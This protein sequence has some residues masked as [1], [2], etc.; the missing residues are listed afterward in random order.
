MIPVNS[1]KQLALALLSTER[2]YLIFEKTSYF[3]PVVPR[4]LL[5]GLW[6]TV[7]NG[8]WPSESVTRKARRFTKSPVVPDE[9]DCSGIDFHG[10]SFVSCLDILSDPRARGDE[11]SLTHLSE[12]IEINLLDHFLS[13]HYF[14][15]HH[16]ETP[17]AAIHGVSLDEKIDADSRMQKLRA[18]LASDKASVGAMNLE[19]VALDRLKTQA[20]FDILGG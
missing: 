3:D 7:V 5:D 20:I 14:S 13:D 18:Q 12:E 17:G 8:Q 16:H 1:R 11:R 9:N 15:L 6:N 10:L 2:L 4:A 19:K